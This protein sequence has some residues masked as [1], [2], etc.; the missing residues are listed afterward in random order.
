MQDE[1][2]RLQGL[3]NIR[4]LGLE[5]LPIQRP[6]KQRYLFG[7]YFLEVTKSH[8]LLELHQ[9]KPTTQLMLC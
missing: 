1:A 8:K 4:T 9:E 7:G 5:R 3:F 2:H 6:F